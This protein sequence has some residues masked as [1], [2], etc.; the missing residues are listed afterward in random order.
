MLKTLILLIKTL[1]Q[2]LIEIIFPNFCV[3]CNKK[4]TLLCSNCY[5]KI[6]FSSFPFNKLEKLKYIDEIIVICR[7][8]GIIKKLIHEFKY[9]SVINIGKIIA[10]LIYRS[11]NIP[12]CDLLIPIPIH[13]KK[14][15]KRGFNQSE[16]IV[17]ELSILTKIPIR[18]LLLKATNTKSQMS[19][20]DIKER[21]NN[22]KNSFEIKK[23]IPSL[24]QKVILI[25]DIVTTGSTLD[26]CAKI[27]KKAG[28]KKVVG[29]VLAKG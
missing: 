20:R 15:D 19:I 29:L 2:A 27:L 1:F 14:L 4:D 26:E 21:K 23:N 17:R 7:Y 10:K 11:T 16:K 28:V 13:K 5:E 18:N 9:K 25:D 24:P 6:E 12:K 22:L 3:G 8:Q